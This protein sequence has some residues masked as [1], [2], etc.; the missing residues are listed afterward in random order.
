[1]SFGWKVWDATVKDYKIGYQA[2]KDNIELGQ[3][4]GNSKFL[5]T[6]FS[7]LTNSVF[8]KVMWC[9]TVKQAWDKL[10]VIYEGASKVKESNIHTYR[11]NF[12]TLKMKEDENIGE[13]LLR[14][15]EVV[16][17]IRGLGG[18]LKEK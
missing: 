3:Y 11:G 16:N 13:Y 2:P 1:M 18:K 12:E 4:E 7:E 14:V 9:K 17:V 6:I 5:N 10:K 8:T 15:D